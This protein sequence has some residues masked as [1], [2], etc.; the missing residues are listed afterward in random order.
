MENLF[1]GV[2]T[3]YYLVFNVRPD[4]DN[5]ALSLRW[6]HFEKVV[7]ALVE[8]GKT[9]PRQTECQMFFCKEFLLKRVAGKLK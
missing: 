6:F 2:S 7:E 4:H 3:S 1:K 8:E 9:W 5:S